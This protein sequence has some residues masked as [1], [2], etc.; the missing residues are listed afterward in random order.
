MMRVGKTFSTLHALH[1]YITSSELFKIVFFFQYGNK[2]RFSCC[3]ALR[4]FNLSENLHDLT[5]R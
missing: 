2:Y 4:R 3:C 1:A 5:Y